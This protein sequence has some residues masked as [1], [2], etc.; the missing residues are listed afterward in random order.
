MTI[1]NKCT[2]QLT[3]VRNGNITPIHQIR[4]PNQESRGPVGGKGVETLKVGKALATPLVL[5]LDEQ[6]CYLSHKE[7]MLIQEVYLITVLVGI[8]FLH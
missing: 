3:I 4:K 5:V 2:Y 6:T 7:N 1:S 8:Q